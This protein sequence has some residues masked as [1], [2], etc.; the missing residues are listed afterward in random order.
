MT[1]RVVFGGVQAGDKVLQLLDDATGMDNALS[2]EHV[3]LEVTDGQMDLSL[4]QLRRFKEAISYAERVLVA[5]REQS[6]LS[7]NLPLP[8]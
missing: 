8:L 7:R 2:T 1:D 5:R 3:R 6:L 4:A